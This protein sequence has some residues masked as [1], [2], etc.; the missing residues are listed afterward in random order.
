ML[1]K[2]DE[3]YPQKDDDEWLEDFNDIND[4]EPICWLPDFFNNPDLVKRL[5]IVLEANG[6]RELWLQGEIYRYLNENEIRAQTNVKFKSVDPYKSYDLVKKED[7]GFIIEIKIIGGDHQS[8][9]LSIFEEDFLRLYRLHD[10]LHKT[11][12]TINEIH[13]LDDNFI[14]QVKNMKS[15]KKLINLIKKE[16][17][18]N[19]NKHKNI[20]ENKS[21]IIKKLQLDI[22]DSQPKYVILILDN[23]FETKLYNQLYDYNPSFSNFKSGKTVDPRLIYSQYYES[24]C[25]LVWEVI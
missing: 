15:L 18:P 16:I 5:S 24:F 22:G 8:K 12:E 2:R 17:V 14:D 20:T 4:D 9:M 25:I 6:C 23:E 7:N 19:S 3:S 13:S 1:K 10:N 11:R 21:S